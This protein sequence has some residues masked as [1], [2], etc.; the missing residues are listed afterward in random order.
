MTNS[1]ATPKLR[2][3]I[4]SSS[5][6]LLLILAIVVFLA[7]RGYTG[8]GN[9]FSHLATSFKGGGDLSKTF[10]LA[11]KAV[12][13]T[14]FGNAVGQLVDT[15]GKAV[16]IGMH[17]FKTN[18]FGVYRQELRDQ[19]AKNEA[20]EGTVAERKTAREARKAAKLAA[21]K[22]RAEKRTTKALAQADKANARAAEIAKKNGIKISDVKA[23][24]ATTAEAISDLTSAKSTQPSETP[25][26]V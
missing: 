14:L 4:A 5:N 9:L 1:T 11:V 18:T 6:P 20:K 10:D 23:E 17:P 13:E 24:M 8:V 12:Q 25:A 2:Q 21:Q 16:Y 19:H 3:T 26:T 15:D 22:V 7:E